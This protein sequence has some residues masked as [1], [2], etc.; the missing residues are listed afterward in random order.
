MKACPYCA[1]RIQDA[2]IVCR[3]CNRDLPMQAPKPEIRWADE[4][5]MSKTSK[6]ITVFAGV[7]A[8]I[9][10]IVVMGG[11]MS[12][13]NS[14]TEPT[15]SSVTSQP[16]NNTPIASQRPSQSPTDSSSGYSKARAEVADM[17]S[18]G[19]I[20]EENGDTFVVADLWYQ[21]PTT[22][23]KRNLVANCHVA[24]EGRAIKVTDSSGRLVASAEG[25]QITIIQ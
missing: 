7:L 16:V 24:H 12:D 11:I 20:L 5:P 17:K 22:T 10:I 18:L 15:K 2:A 1:E 19:M 3:F 21:L 6:F 13:C 8:T 14:K 4:E 23:H 25:G 9:A